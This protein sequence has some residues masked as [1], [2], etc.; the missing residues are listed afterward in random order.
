MTEGE[1]R[2]MN[3]SILTASYPVDRLTYEE[4]AELAQTAGE[5]DGLQY[6]QLLH[7]YASAE[8]GVSGFYVLAYDDDEDRLVA[9]ASA[10]DE[11]GF[12][13]FESSL[14][15]HPLY[16]SIG[17]GT[18]IHEALEQALAVRQSAGTLMLAKEHAPYNEVFLQKCGYGYSF[19]EATFMTQPA[20]LQETVAVTLRPY[21][22]AD[23]ARVANL[24]EQAFGDTLEES[25]QLLEYNTAQQQ[26]MIWVAEQQGEVV[27]TI[28]TTIYEDELNITALAVEQTMRGQGI[29]SYIIALA[30]DEACKENVATITLDVESENEQAWSF[31]M[32][33]GF[34]KVSQTNYFVKLG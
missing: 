5:T 29:G 19:S 17:V 33:N 32:K 12:H 23:F 27:G 3:I 14:V 11:I 24:Y 1:E 34:E 21:A 15:V 31:Y 9:A 30:K 16:R 28:T 2:N 25:E 6:E 4:V 18:A 26:T 20:R 8:A 22:T 10:I 13:T 7:L